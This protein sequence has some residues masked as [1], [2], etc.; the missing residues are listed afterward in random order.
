MTFASSRQCEP[1]FRGL[2]ISP[3]SSSY[4]RFQG[5]VVHQKPTEIIS[6]HFPSSASH[7][8]RNLFER[9]LEG[10]VNSIFAPENEER[11]VLSIARGWTVKATKYKEQLAQT[12]IMLLTRN[13]TDDMCDGKH[14]AQSCFNN[15]L[16]PLKGIAPLVTETSFFSSLEDRGDEKTKCVIM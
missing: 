1:M 3:P 9:Q 4:V 5:S 14:G 13:S 10:S 11:H 12:Y 2:A 16:A 8:D 6:F 15:L 7:A